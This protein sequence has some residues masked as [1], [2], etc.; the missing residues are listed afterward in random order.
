MLA[1]HVLMLALTRRAVLIAPVAAA[2]TAAVAAEPVRIE[3]LKSPAGVEWAEL[4]A[5]TG[6]PPQSGQRVTIDYMMTRRG[7]AKIYSTVDGH[8]PFTWTLGDGSVI[9]GLEQAVVGTEG[10]PPLLPGGVRRVIVPQAR[11]Y[12]VK[13]ATWETSVR[14]V[15]P[16]PPEFVWGMTRRLSSGAIAALSYPMALLAPAH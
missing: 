11:G 1:L 4:K 14:E 16:V 5:G 9:E 6:L 8:Q 10:V 15:G 13:L 7:G 12:G 2:A 3:Y